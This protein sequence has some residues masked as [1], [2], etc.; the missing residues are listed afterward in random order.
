MN[1]NHKHHLVGTFRYI[2]ELLGDAGYILAMTDGASPFARY[3]QDSS[4]AQRKVIADHIGDI[5]RAM[6]QM[7]SDHDLPPPAP[8]CGA[9][10]AVQTQ[11][12]SARMAVAEIR[13]KTMRGYG[14]LSEGDIERIDGIVATLDAALARLAA[15]LDQSP[16]GELSGLPQPGTPDDSG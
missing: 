11:V 13:P 3:T 15:C 14:S 10:W 8:E 6:A 5:R 16:E 9:L 2:D 12:S 7:M 1:Q 4:P